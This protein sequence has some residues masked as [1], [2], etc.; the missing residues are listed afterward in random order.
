LAYDEEMDYESL[1]TLESVIRN[2]NFERAA[3]ELFVTQSAISQRINQLEADFG[4]RLLIRDLPYRATEL[5]E[6][7]LSH[8]RKVLSLEQALDLKSSKEKSERPT[9]RISMNV[10]TLEIWFKKVLENQELA[11]LLNLEITIDDEKFT[12]NYLK[13][14]SV[15]IS[16]GIVKTPVSN[17][18]CVKLG[19]MSYVL[20]ANPEF[21]KSYV[22]KKFS[23][24]NFGE[25]PAIVFNDRDD[26]HTAY[27]KKYFHFNGSYPKTS[28]PSITG[29]KSALI[30]GFGYGLQ[31][32]MV[33]QKE[34]KARE[35]VLLDR[36]HTYERELYLHH[37]NYQTDAVKKL[38]SVILDASQSLQ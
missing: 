34:L 13:S 15:D 10:D 35:L 4:Q 11:K 12:L 20:V 17:H 27:L 31:P 33:V 1:K 14:G 2:Q 25:H 3:K 8:Y 5:G 7:I 16:I 37:W 24:F 36:E 22:P 18:D 26:L 23:D 28:I 38:I 29:I 19:N 21:K 6:K 30:S 9:V 32:L